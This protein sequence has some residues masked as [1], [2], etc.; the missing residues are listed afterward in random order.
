VLVARALLVTALTLGGTAVSVAADPAGQPL[1]A[2][3]V[4]QTSE[5]S[6]AIPSGATSQL[7]TGLHVVGQNAADFAIEAE[8]CTATPI[9]GGCS[10]QVRFGPTGAGRRLAALEVVDSE[11]GLPVVLE[12]IPLEGDGFIIGPHLAV[13]PNLVDLSAP[14]PGTPISIAVT[15]DG[16]QP[17]RPTAAT[18]G[19]GV[20]GHLAVDSQACLNHEL[21]PGA[22]CSIVL[23]WSRGTASSNA[24]WSATLRITG[25]GGIHAKVRLVAGQPV[26]RSG[27]S[28]TPTLRFVFGRVTV[29]RAPPFHNRR[30]ITIVV[31]S[32][33][34]VRLTGYVA[35]P[36]ARGVHARY[37]RRGY[38]TLAPMT[39][40][41]DGHYDA[42]LVATP[43]GRWRGTPRQKAHKDFAA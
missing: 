22:S 27:A 2:T 38:T 18:V 30:R 4:G 24:T 36:K 8:T 23:T 34:P 17:A 21:A 3:R 40:A 28:E 1:P 20:Q 42:H 5:I 6:V 26:V 39:L 33:F 41:R 43:D 15:N 19:H 29:H 14:A 32:T 7:V 16:D 12:D 31:Y 35:G 9:V 37:L 11:G 13:S 10:A 25:L